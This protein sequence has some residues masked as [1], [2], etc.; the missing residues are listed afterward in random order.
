M[1]DELKD[2]STDVGWGKTTT[3]GTIACAG[4]AQQYNTGDWRS[5][6]PVWIIEKCTQCLLCCPVCP[7][8]AILVNDEQKRIEFDYNH[9]KGCG[10]CVEV[11]PFD[12]IDFLDEAEQEE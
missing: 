1:S 11:C 3:G 5:M 8:T 9:C 2:V 6:R 10:V 4:N 7:D 12:A